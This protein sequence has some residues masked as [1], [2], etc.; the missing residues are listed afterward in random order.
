M[1][2]PMGP[3]YVVIS[4]RLVQELIDRA[5]T[6]GFAVENVQVR[7]PFSGVTAGRKT[8]KENYHRLAEQ[9]TEAVADETGTPEWPGIY[10]GTRG[11]FSAWI[12]SFDVERTPVVW[13]ASETE[14]SLL[15]LCGSARNVIGYEAPRQYSGWRPSD[16]GGLRE[17]VL[18]LRKKDPRSLLGY[19]ADQEMQREMASDAAW[20]TAGL[21]KSDPPQFEEELDV[22]LRPYVYVEGFEAQYETG[23]E[24]KYERVIVGAP[25][26]ARPPSDLPVPGHKEQP[27]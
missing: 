13:M 1:V 19:E 15:V 17:I 6:S 3:E 24:V 23:L 5:A 9:I 8:F 12:F 25:L 7:P 11:L 26:W 22:L 14:G 21:R 2:S 18:A 10:I 20:I 27:G 4:E 16:S